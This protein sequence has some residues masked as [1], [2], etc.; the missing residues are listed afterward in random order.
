[1][2]QTQKRTA[3]RKG[4]EQAQRKG[5]ILRSA[6]E[7]FFK[8][9]FLSTTMDE[10][11]RGCDLAKGTIYLYFKSKEELYISLMVEGLGLLRDDLNTIGVL[12]LQADQLLGEILGVYFAFYQK[13]P[14]YF[15]IMFL[16]SQ[17]DV[18]ER[19][20]DEL[21]QECLGRA[22]ECMQVL[23]EIIE[24]GTRSGIFRKVDSWSCAIIVW[25]TINGII[26]QYEQDP[27]YRCEILKV[28]LEEML[29]AALELALGGL[30]INNP[31][32]QG[33]AKSAS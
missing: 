15:R 14:Q 30:L 24:K 25:T 28:N 23:N 4:R 33:K 27:F 22:V 16:S 26:T 21:M 29:R 5:D 32:E 6:R 17:P 19:V 1:M 2:S 20:R 12:D 8:K 11:A 9:G 31:S 10:I 7:V 3:L 13:N 18:R